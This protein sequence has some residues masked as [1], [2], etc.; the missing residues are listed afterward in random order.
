MKKKIIPFLIAIGAAG[1]TLGAC[2]NATQPAETTT[3]AETTITDATTT[4]AEAETTTIAEAET[5]TIAEAQGNGIGQVFSFEA[6]GDKWDMTVN[7]VDY[8]DTLDAVSMGSATQINPE[9]GMRFVVLN[10]TLKNTGKEAQYIDNVPDMDF[11][12]ALIYDTDYTFQQFQVYED[13]ENGITNGD[14]F[15]I[16]VQPL[17][18]KKGKFVFQVPAEVTETSKSLVFKGD[19]PMNKQVYFEINLR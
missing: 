2:G 7:S 16:S 15:G 19:N 5:T 9:S 11:S 12:K 3:T 17:S 13:T 14:S 1:V 6:S 8:V 4:I 10:T 18:E